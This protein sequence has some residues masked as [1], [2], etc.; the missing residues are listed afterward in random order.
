MLRHLPEAALAPLRATCRDLK[1]LADTRLTRVTVPYDS[2]LRHSF[3]RTTPLLT[4]TSLV[5]EMPSGTAR[6]GGAA[7][8]AG[9]AGPSGVVAGGSAASEQPAGMQQ[10][11]VLVLK[12]PASLWQQLQPVQLLHQQQQ[13]P[14]PQGPPAAPAAGTAAPA[15]PAPAGTLAAAPRPPQPLPALLPPVTFSGLRRH[16]PGLIHLTLRNV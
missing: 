8:A 2:M 1:A 14:A 13:Q 4:V 5:L 9:A 12:H 6:A 15:V 16:L 11:A 10:P 3:W 7:A